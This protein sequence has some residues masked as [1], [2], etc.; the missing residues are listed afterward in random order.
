[1]QKP[2]ITLHEVIWEITDNCGQNCT[3]CGSKETLNQT[4]IESENIRAIV[5]EIAKFPP[6]AIDISG[7]N[8][9]LVSLSDH[10]Y[11]V[12]QLGSVGVQCKILFNPF[13]RKDD[14]ETDAKIELYDW[15]GLSVNTQEEFNEAKSWSVFDKMTIIT[16]FNV[17]NVFLFKEIEKF[18]IENNLVWQV[19]YT[20]YKE[21]DMLEIYS[22]KEAKEY[23]HKLIQHSKS[24]IIAADNM[25][26]NSPCSAGIASLGILAN[27]DVVPCLS[28]RSW[29][30]DLKELIFGNL[31]RKTPQDTLSNIW[32]KKFSQF[33]CEEFK[34]CKDHCQV[35]D[36]IVD[37]EITTNAGSGITWFPAPEYPTFDNDKFPNVMMYA[38]Q[39]MRDISIVYGVQPSSTFVYGVWSDTQNSSK[40]LLNETND[41]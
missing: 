25:N 3:Y 20:M 10:E 15:V 38:V 16:N 37:C 29:V 4:P 6:K 23:L 33:R 8:P 18:V 5:D 1:M 22:N 2:H 41:N 17:G 26:P 39:G 31:L 27:G 13:N 28:M 11:L 21:K 30:D 34:C 19:Q 36:N 32:I 40:A 24:N 12:R 9:L 35:Y 7:G 14:K